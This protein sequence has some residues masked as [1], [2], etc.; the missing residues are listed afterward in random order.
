LIPFH[1]PFILNT[2]IDK[3][4]ITVDGAIDILEAS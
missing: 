3:K 2:D 4:T 1:A